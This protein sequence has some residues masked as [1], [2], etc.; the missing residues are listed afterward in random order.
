MGKM[1]ALYSRVT[2]MVD[3]GKIQEAIENYHKALARQ[4]DYQEAREKLN[5]LLSG[6]L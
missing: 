3:Q 5:L 2:V 1:T 6:A 4:P